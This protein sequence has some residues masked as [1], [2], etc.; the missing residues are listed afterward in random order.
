MIVQLLAPFIVSLVSL[1]EAP[2]EITLQDAIDQNL[3]EVSLE[4]LGDYSGKCVALSVS[5]NSAKKFNLIVEPGDLFISEFDENQ[6]ILVVEEQV[7]AMEDKQ[8][9]FRIEGF[10]CE[11]HDSSPGEGDGFTYTKTSDPSLVKLASYIDGKGIDEDNKQSAIWA[12][13]DGES[14]SDIYPDDEP[15]K[16]L[17]KYVC[18]LTNQEDVW[19][20]TK[21][22][23]EVTEDRRIIAQPILI[24]GKVEYTV[25]KPGMLYCSV[26]DAEGNEIMKMGNGSK[27]PYA[28]DLSFEFEGR[29]QGWSEG[30]YYVKVRLDDKEIHS[31]KFS[32]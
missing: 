19:F 14:V 6:N 21:K 12:V 4:S 26:V 18:D 22:N 30:D 16:E 2:K 10:C 29:V 11:A 32:V 5:S 17:R 28:A 3:I 20:N 15:S 13:S 31:Q 1:V 25:E 9:D 7:L 23:Y 8:D 24:T 27:I